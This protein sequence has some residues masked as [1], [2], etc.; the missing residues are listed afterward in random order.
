MYY[1]YKQGTIGLMVG[2]QSVNAQYEFVKKTCKYVCPA[3]QLFVNCSSAKLMLIETT[4]LFDSCF[5]ILLS[6][7][8]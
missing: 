6:Y 3:L 2:L 8:D 5:T 4:V 7:L 1:N